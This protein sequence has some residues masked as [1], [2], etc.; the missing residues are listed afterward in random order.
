MKELNDIKGQQEKDMLCPT[1][2]LF[3]EKDE[4]LVPVK[5]LSDEKQ[6]TA[7]SVQSVKKEKAPKKEIDSTGLRLL[8]IMADSIELTLPVLQQDLEASGFSITSEAEL[9]NKRVR[10]VELLFPA[11][12][13]L[14]PVI[15]DCLLPHL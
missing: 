9:S 10:L 3:D 5:E 11:F 8:A 13:S 2:K 15:A 1:P 4:D 6:M 7:R 14:I 12:N